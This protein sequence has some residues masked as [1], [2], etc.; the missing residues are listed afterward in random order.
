[1]YGDVI[2]SY[3]HLKVPRIRGLYFCLIVSFIVDFIQAIFRPAKF[4][5]G[6]ISKNHRH[7]IVTSHPRCIVPQVRIEPAR[8]HTC[9]HSWSACRH[10]NFRNNSLKYF[11]LP[12]S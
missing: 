1:M 3:E 2:V 11:A 4:N 7:S 8:H 6:Q 5:G 9:M 12:V 10:F